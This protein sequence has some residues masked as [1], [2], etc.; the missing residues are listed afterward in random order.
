[1]IYGVNVRGPL[2]VLRDNWL[3]G[4][5]S[6]HNLVEWVENVKSNL[7]DFA[8][9]ANDKSALSK[10]KMKKYYDRSVKGAITFTPGDMVLV[11]TPGLSS[12]FAD[13]WS[14][15]FEITKQISP[16]TWEIATPSARK[17]SK[18]L[19]SNM[20]RPWHTAAVNRVVVISEA[21]DHKPSPLSP[22]PSCTLTNDQSQTLHSLQ[23]EFASILTATPGCTSV[24]DMSIDTGENPPFQ[25]YPYRL[26]VKLVV[27]VKEAI[28]LL[29]S[30]SIIE[31]CSGP[32]SSP[33]LTCVEKGWLSSDMH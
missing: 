14:G 30:H 17:K 24:I 9:I 33:M 8:I 16:V 5:T 15:P 29:L 26:P 13:S 12:K 28:D 31:P 2:E 32:W 7:C 21:D 23:A 27:P 19:H 22:S 6:D 1:L 20:L 3:E 11:R 4:N 10:S 25:S 18:V